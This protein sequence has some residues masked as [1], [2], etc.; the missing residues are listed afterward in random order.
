MAIW[1][2]LGLDST[3]SPRG[4]D[5]SFDSKEVKKRGASVIIMAFSFFY[6]SQ[7]QQYQQVVLCVDKKSSLAM[8]MAASHIKYVSQHASAERKARIQL[9]VILIYYMSQEH[10][11]NIH[12]Y[13]L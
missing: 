13:Y 6:F 3:F 5:P 9:C 8:L 10:T 12:Y 1:L 11:M 7:Y 2:R 4:T